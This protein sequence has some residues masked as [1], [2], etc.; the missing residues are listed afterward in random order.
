MKQIK[1]LNIFEKSSLILTAFTI[2]GTGVLLWQDYKITKTNTGVL[3]DIASL[4]KEIKQI[5]NINDLEKTKSTI[6]TY[7]KALDHRIPWSGIV[8]EIFRQETN[9]TK[10]FSFSSDRSKKI[11]ITGSS[12]NWEEVSLLI[13]RLKANPRIENP[14]I[15]SVSEG[16]EGNNFTLTFNFIAG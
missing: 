12:T 6:E 2:F 7:N 14:F 9:H 3:S 13:E 16:E 4:E 10:F 1:K 11:N 8:G 5:N 15:S